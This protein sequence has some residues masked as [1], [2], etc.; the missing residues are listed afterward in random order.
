[1]IQLPSMKPKNKHTR[2]LPKNAS[3]ELF[4]WIG[5]AAILIDYALLSVGLLDSDSLAYHFMFMI[6]S[7]GL[8]IITFRHRA[9]QSFTVNTTFMLLA[10]V[11]LVRIT[12]FA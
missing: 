2:H 10:I 4:G 1:M 7:A 11:A 8:A 9:F 12:F 3:A 5:A 6:G